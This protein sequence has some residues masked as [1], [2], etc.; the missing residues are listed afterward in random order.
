MNESEIR[1]A[2][3]GELTKIAPE[4]EPG[5]LEAGTPLRNQ[6]DLDSMDWL[7]FIIALHTRLKVEIPETDYTK[8]VTL[9]DVI[10][11][12]KGKLRD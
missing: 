11:Y 5:E 9:N 3:L 6:V 12:L 4:V 1:S 10:G 8:L 7:N 2:V